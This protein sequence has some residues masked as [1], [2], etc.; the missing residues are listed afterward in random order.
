MY[1]T[2]KFSS[3]PGLIATQVSIVVGVRAMCYDVAFKVKVPQNNSK[4]AAERATCVNRGRSRV[5]TDLV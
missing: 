5:K 1:T 3:S 2:G 4:E